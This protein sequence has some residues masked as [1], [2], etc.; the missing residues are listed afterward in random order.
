[1]RMPLSIPST[2]PPPRL[3]EGAWVRVK[4][5]WLTGRAEPTSQEE[6]ESW[7]ADVVLS[8]QERS[9]GRGNANRIVAAAASAS[10]L[11]L[12]VYPIHPSSRHAHINTLECKELSE[13]VWWTDFYLEQGLK[14]LLHCR[15]GHH[16]T[17]VAIYLLLRSI[18]EEPAQCLSLMKAMRPAMHTEISRRTQHGHLFSKA[19]PIFASPEFRAG[20]SCMRRW[21]LVEPS[22]K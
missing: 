21:N 2:T 8:L 6:L 12:L 15:H 18:L 16:R 10:G 9:A 13:V 17:G 3:K 14:V 19:E 20:V 11:V 22:C 1:M 4:R 7:G 5:G